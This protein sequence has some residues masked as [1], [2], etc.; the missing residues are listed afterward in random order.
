MKQKI[1]NF[2]KIFFLVIWLTIS[3]QS[4]RFWNFFKKSKRNKA[5][6]IFIFSFLITGLIGFLIFDQIKS[7]FINRSSWFQEE[8]IWQTLVVIRDQKN[9]DPVEDLR[10]SLKR[11]DVIVVR[12]E[13]H[14]WSKT[15]LVS[16]LI[17]KIRAKPNEIIKLLEPLEK[18]IDQ[19]NENNELK[20]EVIVARRYKI[21]LEKTGFSG[22]Q[23]ING[24]PLLDRV[25]NFNELVIE[26]KSP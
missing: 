15:E 26:K 16:Y 23:V 12:N 19:K 17:V 1:I 21:D 4:K 2:I 18:E 22:D 3:Y 7:Y 11:G 9:A 20:K 10:S 14:Q 5:L 24:Q 8:E 13:N 25:F 6:V